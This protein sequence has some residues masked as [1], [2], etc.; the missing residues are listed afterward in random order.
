MASDSA[1]TLITVP[2]GGT[3]SGVIRLVD[4]VIC[5]RILDGVHFDFDFSMLRPE[6]KPVVREIAD[7]ITADTARQV[8]VVGHTDRVGS[9]A[10]N[11]GLSERRARSVFAYI[12]GQPG[13]WMDLLRTML[14]TGG[15]TAPRSGTGQS[16]DRWQVREIQYM[17][18][19]LRQPSSGQPYY[20]GP[21][22]NIA[23]SGTQAALSAFRTDNSLPSGGGPGQKWAGVDEPTW[24]LLFQKYIQ[25]DALAID[26]GRF[27]TP[28]ILGCGEHF[29]RVETR[30]PGTESEDRKDAEAR[31]ETN[32][33]VEFLLIPPKLV[34][35]EVTCESI[36]DPNRPIVVC[37]G[38]PQPIT[39]TLDFDR[40]G[41][42]GAGFVE[43]QSDQPAVGLDVGI[44]GQ[45]GFIQRRT[46]DAQGRVRLDDSATTQ[47][48]F[49]VSVEGDF[50]LALRDP[51]QG[52]VRNNE[53]LLHLTSSSTVEILV[54]QVGG[55]IT[56][57]IELQ[58]EYG[59]PFQGTF[60]LTL[61][62]GEVLHD[63]TTDVKG[64]WTRDNM[65]AGQYRVTIA[66]RLL[67]LVG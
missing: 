60:D 53:V 7:A 22:D 28:P 33:R 51:S 57:Q 2:R 19:V 29:P 1:S 21:I 66:D 63:E 37:P 45:G 26:Q 8:L 47:G 20:D 23:G 35:S 32:R 27:L 43:G 41:R 49:R 40:R 3:G 17:L 12:S 67:G 11:Q 31:L 9:N 16:F 42:S 61:P 30:P 62:N 65:P 34:P 52:Q 6:G 18:S 15:G 25:Q 36:H 38:D 50:K 14:T 58:N 10:Y 59:E 55:L 5:A 64:A 24:E 39:I 48:D 13:L 56:V 54:T 4:D 46:T 44:T